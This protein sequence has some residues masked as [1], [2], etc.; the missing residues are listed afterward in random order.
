MSVLAKAGCLL[1]YTAVVGTAGVLFQGTFG[2]DDQ[3][4]YFHLI[5][6][7][8]TAVTFQSF[9]YAGGTDNATVIPAGGFAPE[10]SLFALVGADYV[11]ANSDNG[12]HCG[13]TGP[14][15]VTGNCDDPFLQTILAPGSYFVALSVD[16]NVPSTGNLLDGFK[17][18]GHPGF[19][20]A[21]G[22][23]TGQF[24]DVTDALFRPRTGN[25][26]L[27]IAGATSVT[28]TTIPEPATWWPLLSCGLLGALRLRRRTG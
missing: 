19:T 1:V 27:D 15:P 18:T 14:D 8:A 3:V 6:S 12:G 26:A 4:Q 28:P 5:V 25:W 10:L 13:T 23:Q 22:G 21:E 7:S 20:C 24:C 16:D 11:L 9:G 17:Q 2:A